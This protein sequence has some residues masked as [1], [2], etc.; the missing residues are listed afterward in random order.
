MQTGFILAMV[1]CEVAALMGLAALFVTLSN[2]A[3]LLFALGALGQALHFPRREEVM[4]AY[5]KPGM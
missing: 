5:Y 4:S 1:L 3:Y 2:Y